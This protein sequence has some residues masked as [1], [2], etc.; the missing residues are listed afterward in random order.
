MVAAA[1]R[2]LQ[3]D[4]AARNGV[5]S[6]GPDPDIARPPA[7]API[8]ATQAETDTA[9]VTGTDTETETAAGTATMADPPFR[10]PETRRAAPLSLPVGT[11]VARP[12]VGPRAPLR[13]ALLPVW[14]LPSG[15]STGRC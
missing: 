11:R 10:A 5:A 3:T 13:P 14:P 6:P 8:R 9:A 4:A 7:P 1:G 15:E 12:V 2:P